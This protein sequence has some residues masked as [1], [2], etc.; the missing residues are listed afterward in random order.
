M[1]KEIINWQ[2][3][4]AQAQQSVLS[5]PAIAESA[6]LSQQVTNILNKVKNEGDKG[7]VELTEKFDGIKLASLTL[8]SDALSNAKKALSP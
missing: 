5:R 4:D 6:L 1:I 7:L 2:A 3:L 8:S